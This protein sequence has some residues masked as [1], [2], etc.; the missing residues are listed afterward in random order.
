VA[1]QQ[2]KQQAAFDAATHG[3]FQLMEVAAGLLLN[4]FDNGDSH[5]TT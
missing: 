5:H 3:G 1:L 2:M 4:L